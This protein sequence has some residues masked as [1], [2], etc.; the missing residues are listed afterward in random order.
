M[1]TKLMRIDRKTM[2][3]DID[4]P[5]KRV[6]SQGSCS[7][8]QNDT[9]LKRCICRQKGISLKLSRDRQLSTISSAGLLCIQMLS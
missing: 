8:G 3:S 6:L 5:V 7:R 4:S 2:N 1:Y 9:N